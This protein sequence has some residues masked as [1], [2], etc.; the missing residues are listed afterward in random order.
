MTEDRPASPAKIFA[1]GG[2]RIVVAGRELRLRTRKEAMLL[3]KLAL[4]SPKRVRRDTC[5]AMLWPDSVE[6]RA[7]HSL[8]EALRGIEQATGVHVN[9]TPETI[10]LDDAQA[11]ID[12]RELEEAIGRGDV[13]TASRLW[14]GG[15]LAGWYPPTSEASHWVDATSASLGGALEKMLRAQLAARRRSTDSHGV[16]CAVEL[17]ERLGVANAADRE[18]AAEAAQITG[19][20]SLR[21]GESIPPRMPVDREGPFV[22]RAEEMRVLTAEL[23]RALA[24]E[25]RV[26]LVAGEAGIG[27]TRTCQRLARLAAL[28][29]A[30]LFLSSCYELEQS[31][32][33]GA[34]SEAFSGA[35]TASDVAALKPALRQVL[36]E[37]LPELGELQSA[38]SGTSWRDN[39][40]SALRALTALAEHLCRDRIGFFLFDNVQWADATSCQAIH[41]LVRGAAPS[42]G[43]LVVLVF[44][45]EDLLLNEMAQLLTRSAEDAGASHLNLDAMTDE[46]IE[47]Q[48]RNLLPKT[49]E[50]LSDL[51]AIAQGN[52]FFARELA[53]ARIATPRNSRRTSS[54][55]EVIMSRVRRLRADEQ[56]ILEILAVGGTPLSILSIASVAEEPVSKV[57]RI[58]HTLDRRGFTKD[59]NGAIAV[60]HDIMRHVIYSTLTDSSRLALHGSIAQKLENQS[61]PAFLAAHFSSAGLR[62]QAARYA[63]ASAEEARNRKAFQEEVRW[64]VVALENCAEDEARSYLEVVVDRLFALGRYS[65]A[66]DR[67][68]QNGRLLDPKL[69]VKLDLARLKSL[70]RPTEGLDRCDTLFRESVRLEMGREAIESLREKM[71]L[72][73][74]SGET[75]KV[76]ATAETLDAFGRSWHNKEEGAYGQAW[77]LLKLTAFKPEVVRERLDPL[78][79]D[80]AEYKSPE[81]QVALQF[82]DALDEYNHGRLAVAGAKLHRSIKTARAAGALADEIQMRALLV[83][84]ATESMRFWRAERHARIALEYSRLAD[85]P[86]PRMLTLANLAVSRIERGDRMGARDAANALLE[87][88]QGRPMWLM[89]AY[90]MAVKGEIALC[91]GR[92]REAIESATE[93]EVCLPSVEKWVSDLSFVAVFLATVLRRTNHREA[94]CDLLTTVANHTAGRYQVCYWTVTLE[95]LRLGTH[96]MMEDPIATA[97]TIR[98]ESEANACRLIAAKAE[99]VLEGLQTEGLDGSSRGRDNLGPHIPE[100]SREPK[101]TT[102]LFQRRSGAHSR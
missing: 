45:P 37:V 92:L 19:W 102:Q 81:V 96:S 84:I 66:A 90:A 14:V 85:A 99:R 35:V 68:S 36:G 82:A 59:A 73:G 40:N 1:L 8:S 61:Q 50:E 60:S 97:T 76:L 62:T 7:R 47:I 49:P 79:E 72:A 46:E 5:V 95:L 32:A 65:E 17:L 54:V 80:R 28:R 48:I 20:E 74:D 10:A 22:G 71:R 78:L 44:R 70:S 52:P 21:P 42:S 63:T 24:G 9:R 77:A 16:T 12:A 51:A 57:L 41:H 18:A 55:S 31:V 101:K 94:A 87:I 39:S 91:E 30:R 75:A 98:R 33:F 6:G 53:L 100:V 4:E 56:E 67:L 3:L 64:L 69:R 83:P 34:I 43:A 2:F 88:E 25:L 13:D 38:N 29:G 93:I 86:W 15:F 11:W 23:E 58:I 27:K 26:V 89:R